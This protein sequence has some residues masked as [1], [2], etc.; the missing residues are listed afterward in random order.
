MKI[1]ELEELILEKLENNN[2]I[3]DF[4]SMKKIKYLDI[5]LE[6]FIKLKNSPFL[7]E[8]NICLDNKIIPIEQEKIMLQKLI[9]MNTLRIFSIELNKITDEEILNIQDKN[10][11]V[12][13]AKI[14]WK[15]K[16]DD[17]IIFNL[18]N[19]FPN[20]KKLT[21][22]QPYKNLQNSEPSLEIRENKN[23][24]VNILKLNYLRNKTKLYC[25][26]YENLLKIY[27]YLEDEIKHLKNFSLFLMIIAK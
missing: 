9:S 10:F 17:C 13:E 2:K 14:T 22:N 23:L 7:E 20:I 21:L 18:Q 1:P 11:S 4:S 27:I 24:K 8:A 3:F 16:S 12:M 19:K 6:S 5:N 25:Q 26:S 15:N